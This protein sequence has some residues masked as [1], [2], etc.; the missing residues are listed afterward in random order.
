MISIKLETIEINHVALL[1]KQ[2]NAFAFPKKKKHVY[3]LSFGFPKGLKKTIKNGEKTK[4]EMIAT[5]KTITV[6][7][8]K[9]TVGIKFDVT[10]TK[11]PMIVANA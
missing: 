1:E 6:K 10:S 9:I 11:K 2:Y 3:F 4:S 7:R 5:T 8:P